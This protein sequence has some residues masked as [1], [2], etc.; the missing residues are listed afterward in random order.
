MA[1]ELKANLL[2]GGLK[3]EILYLNLLFARRI[4]PRAHEWLAAT[5]PCLLGEFL[6][7]FAVEERP[8]EDIR[9]YIDD[10]LKGEMRVFGEGIEERL[11]KVQNT[12]HSIVED[13]VNAVTKGTPVSVDGREGR[14][15]VALLEAIYRSAREG[16]VIRC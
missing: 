5:G 16:R 9:T 3:S 6:F 13:V 10:V 2:A 11:M 7:S 1:R 12:T 15:T 4:T 8:D 14:R